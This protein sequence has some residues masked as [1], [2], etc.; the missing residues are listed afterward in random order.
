[1]KKMNNEKGNSKG[2]RIFGAVALV[3]FIGAVLLAVFSLSNTVSEISEIAVSKT[4]TA[5]LAN[6]GVSDGRRIAVPV[7]YYDQRADECVNMFDVSMRAALE[8]RQFEWTSCEYY[9]G[10]IEQ[11]LVD[12]VLESNYLPSGIGGQLTPNRGLAD[13]TRWFNEV[14]GKSSSY[15]GTI[16]FDYKADGAE[17]SFYKK[18]FYPLD[19]AEFSRGDSV[20][21]DGHNH[22]FTMSFAVPFTALLSGDEM[23]EI[24]ADD[25]T[26]VFVGD[27][28]VI[29]MGGIHDT[30]TGAFQIRDNGEVYSS[31]DGQ[32]MAYTGVTVDKENGSIVR[33]YHADR[34]S[35]S[36]EF[37]VRFSGMNLTLMNTNLAKDGEDAIQV[38]YDPSDPSYVAPLGES[39]VFQPN[40]AKG[41]IVIATIEGAVLIVFSIF[42]VLMAR[43]M[44][45]S[46]NEK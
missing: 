15:T 39:V 11:G 13:M 41:L 10:Q 27:K 37:N 32:T 26:F 28:L 23:L 8:A 45:R 21:S 38:A 7:L 34:D 30:V 22:L 35:A 4:P 2:F 25:D 31:V 20:N 14:E 46:K 5:I 1:M 42:T 3:G 16:S 43:Y 44:I 9:N 24:A 18:Q 12:Y 19:E 36:S 33:V 17:F 40:G 29:D 6:A